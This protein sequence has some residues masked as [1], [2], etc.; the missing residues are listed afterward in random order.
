MDELTPIISKLDITIFASAFFT[1]LIAFLV[2]SMRWWLILNSCGQHV[3]YTQITS[4]YYLGLFSNN[5]LPTAMGGDVVRIVKLRSIGLST[6]QLIFSTLF[7]RIIGLIAIIIMGLIGI[8]FSNSIHESIGEQSLLFVNIISFLAFTL[9]FV[10]LS[11]NIRE[12]LFN[13]VIHKFYF[14]KK[15][16]NFLSYCR[17]NLVIIKNTKIL[18]VS[19]LMSLVSQLLVILTYYLISRSL[20]VELSLLD[21]VLIV[22]VV[23]LF[24]SLPISVGGLGV[25][26]GIMILLLGTVGI[27]TSSAASITFLYLFILIVITLP[28]GLFLF[29]WK[30]KSAINHVNC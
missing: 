25:R 13:F 28:G 3:P 1:H 10:F 24:S 22:P 17:D 16:N 21:Y 11:S 12:K 5:F 2:M 15:L 20:H 27:Q 23:A 7:D 14:W 8:N 9:F 30:N 6:N 26:E 4:A 29:S 18:S 19:V